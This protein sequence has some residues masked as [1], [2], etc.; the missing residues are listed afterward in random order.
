MAN[1]TYERVGELMACVFQLLW[2]R[3][4]GL[5]A[6]EIISLIPEI[7]HLTESEQGWVAATNTTRYERIVR[8]SSMPLVK[9]GWLVKNEKG[10]WYLTESGREASR[11][12]SDAQT[13]YAEALRLSKAGTGNTAEILMSLEIIQERSWQYIEQYLQDRKQAEM[14]R[15]VADLLEALDYHI[16]WLAPAEKVRGQIDM[17]VNADPLGANPT[18]I[19]VQ[20]RHKGQVTTLEGVKSFLS[21]LGPGDFGLLMSSG[22]FTREVRAE[23]ASS[24]YARLNA[25]DLEKFFNLWVRHFEKLSSDAKTRLPLQPIYFISPNAES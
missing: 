10:R 8:L 5:P 18:R 19:L 24:N 6:R 12:F 16:V 9:A 21:V 13:M 3:P 17:V 11:Q 2:N 25:M 23:L 4:D 20:V 22:G 7:I 1:L 14:R 15:L